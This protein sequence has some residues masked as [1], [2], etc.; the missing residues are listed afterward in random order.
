MAKERKLTLTI[1]GN[2]KGAL[3]AMS[4][5]GSAGEGLGSKLG[6]L[7]KKAALAFTAVAAGSAV[8]GKKFVDAASNL[9]ESMSKVNVVF[10][11]S[12]KGVQDFAKKSAASLG[13]SQ[14]SALEA[15][16]TYGNLLKAFGLTNEQATDMSTSM[17]TLAADL[18]SFNNTSIDDALLALR[19]GLSGETEPLKR[20]GVAIND[21]RLKEQALA[22]GLIKTTTGTLPIA[23]KTQAAYALIMKDTALAQGDFERTSDGVANKQRIISAQ[24]ADVTAQIGTA[25]LPAFS[26]LLGVVTDQILPV[27]SEF[28]TALQEGGVSGG[29]DFMIAKVKELAP[30]L[31]QGFV[32]MFNNVGSWVASDG[33][34]LIVRYFNFLTNAL[35]EWILPALPSLIDK[36]VKFNMRMINWITS[37]GIG[38]LVK[39]MSRLGDALVGWVIPMLPKLLDKLKEYAKTF[40]SFLLDT[41][42]PNLLDN[43]QILGDKLVGWIGEAARKVPAQL[44]TFLGELTGWLL[45]NAV[46]KLLEIGL[47][48]LGSLIK[49]TFSLGKDLIIGIGGAVVALVAA[50]PDLFMGFIKGLGNIAVNAVQFFVDKFKMLGRKIAELAVGAVNFLIDKFNAIPLIPNIEKVTLDTGKLTTAMGLTAAEVSTVA[51]T[52]NNTQRDASLYAKELKDVTLQTKGAKA[53]TDGLNETLGGGGG[54]GKG[55]SNALKKAQEQLKK[56]TSALQTNEDRSRSVTDATKNVGKAQDALKLSIANVEKAQARFNMVMGGFPRTSKEAIEATKQ[57]DQANRRLRDSNI[58][59]EQAVRDVAS[60]EKRLADLRA[61]TSDPANV[62]DAERNL[63]RAKFGIEQANFDVI[64][65]EKELAALRATGDANPIELRK[66]EIGLEEAKLRVIEATIG[67]QQATKQLDD[68]RNRAATPEDIAD[69]ERDLEAAK[70]AVVDAIDET[71]DA[72][73][74]Q[75]LAQAFLNEITNGATEGS[76]A[77]KEALDALN[78]AKDDQVEASERVTEA[79]EQERDAVR[80][81]AEAQRELLALQ[82]SVGAGIRAKAEAKFATFNQPIN[83]TGTTTSTQGS[84]TSQPVNGDTSINFNIEASGLS[85]PADIGAEV[86]D[87]LAAYLRTNGNIPINVG[88][89]VGTL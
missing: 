25:L 84:L 62:A 81:L 17:V 12:A 42:L 86:I 36:L 27:L 9:E 67:Q 20:F 82:K 85:T 13:I 11:D 61:L 22:M 80:E 60:A 48:L 37:D 46:P 57:L 71:R 66:R 73:L 64:E 44:V 74:E 45:A 5:V 28:G 4:S 38:M 87:A 51:S 88:S 65:A 40:V 50:L 21:V 19:S 29:I 16:G 2:A 18:A 39:A 56:Y 47:Q 78:E 35:T 6:G 3:S 83:P 32:D 7:G 58:A 55:T 75:S 68:E 24:F 41:A 49:W 63:T 77:Y 26:S 15:A 34:A 72:T 1:L 33:K 70:L 53:S 59:Q 30:K 89:F 43:V 31:L 54:K 8:M 79:L 69:A 23:I 10:G 52:F 14:A 76:D